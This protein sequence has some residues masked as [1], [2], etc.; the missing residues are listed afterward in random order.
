MYRTIARSFFRASIRSFLYRRKY[1][2]RH[3]KNLN[4]SFPSLRRRF[5]I[6]TRLFHI[7][8]CTA[9]GS[10][11][12]KKSYHETK[13][14]EPDFAEHPTISNLSYFA[15]ATISLRH[16]TRVST[17]RTQLRRKKTKYTELV[18][19][20]FQ[21]SAVAMYHESTFLF[22]SALQTESL[23]AKPTSTLQTHAATATHTQNKTRGG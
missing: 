12:T 19:L 7:S 15:S 22:K 9:H 21:I 5:S 8:W 17:G 23:L 18:I 4:V 3:G 10:R 20:L 16:S 13:F 6:K 1:G 14:T 2:A 11:K